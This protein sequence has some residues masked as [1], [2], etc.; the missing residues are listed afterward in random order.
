MSTIVEVDGQECLSTTVSTNI[1]LNVWFH[2]PRMAA[3][4]Q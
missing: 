2:Q 4:S 1:I 3:M